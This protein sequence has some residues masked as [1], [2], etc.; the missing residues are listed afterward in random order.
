MRVADLNMKWSKPMPRAGLHEAD[1]LPRLTFALQ[2]KAR[3]EQL[4]KVTAMSDEKIFAISEN[5]EGGWWYDAEEVPPE[6]QK[7]QG[8]AKW[9][10]WGGITWA[11]PL[12]LIF[13]EG[14]TFKG[15]ESYER[16]LLKLHRDK[17]KQKVLF[18][19]H[20]FSDHFSAPPT[21]VPYG[22]GRRR[23]TTSPLRSRSPR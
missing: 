3:K 11:G 9:H 21:E 6:V 17:A 19:S 2:V 16:D 20:P 8:E 4:Q 23:R 10:V 18:G 7:W 14:G 22:G 5:Q 1:K 15:K 12:P 13:L